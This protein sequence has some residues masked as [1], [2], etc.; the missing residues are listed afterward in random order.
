MTKITNNSRASQGVRDSR[1][2]M[3]LI[4]P[5]RT[6]DLEL[7]DA[8]MDNAKSLPFLGIEGVERPKQ[9]SMTLGELNSGGAPGN[10]P[11]RDRIAQ[12]TDENTRI[13]QELTVASARASELETTNAALVSERDAL[14][15]K[16]QV[17][18]NEKLGVMTG[19]IA[20]HKGG[21]SYSVFDAAGVE[22]LGSLTRDQSD[23]FNQLADDV[24]KTQWVKDNTAPERKE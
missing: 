9:E 11:L 18:E 10:D 23:N 21:G 1:R 17:L 6:E 8:E 2:G 4:D 20:K 22:V 19:L 12:L 15:A 13:G 3:V 14:G 7:D 24:A 5:G 16:V